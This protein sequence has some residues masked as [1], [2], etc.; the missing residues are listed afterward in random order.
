[1]ANNLEGKKTVYRKYDNNFPNLRKIYAAKEDCDYPEFCIIRPIV[2]TETSG[3]RL[4]DCTVHTKNHSNEE[5]LHFHHRN[6]LKD[7]ME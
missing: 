5:E 4:Y 6:T 7:K 2:R 3:K 1:V